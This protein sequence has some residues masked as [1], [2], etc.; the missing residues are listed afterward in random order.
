MFLY[1]AQGTLVEVS[2]QVPSNQPKPASSASSASGSVEGFISL[3]ARSV[4]PSSES[5]KTHS[6]SH[7]N[8]Q[9]KAGTCNFTSCFDCTYDP[10]ILGGKMTCMCLDDNGKEHAGLGAGLEQCVAQNRDITLSS[11]YRLDCK[12]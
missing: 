2:A 11:D 12:K 10:T 5:A 9:L 7:D 6:A 8:T 1:T 3:G 4:I